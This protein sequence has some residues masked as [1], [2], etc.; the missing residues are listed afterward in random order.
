MEFKCPTCKKVISMPDGGPKPEA[1]P[2][3]SDR[4]RMVDLGR[5]L[6]GDYY[7]PGERASLPNEDDDVER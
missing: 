3:C 1:F 7:I 2:F 6:N 5:W 4:C